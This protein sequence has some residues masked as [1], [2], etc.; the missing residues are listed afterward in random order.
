MSCHG[1]TDI[2]ALSETRS[3]ESEAL[4]GVNGYTFLSRPRK[5]E[6]G[7]GV[8]I[9]ISNRLKWI[10][11]YDLESEDLECLWIEL[12]PEKSKSILICVIYKPPVGSR[13]LK[14]SFSTSSFID[15]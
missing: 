7:G 15:Y 2:F 9:Y 8:G 3:G 14:E 10:R 5:K 1:K 6:K 11:R 4:Y 13:Y 12:F